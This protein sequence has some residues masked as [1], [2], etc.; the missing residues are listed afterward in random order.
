MKIMALLGDYPPDESKRRQNA[1]SRS[2]SPGTQ[3]DFSVISESVYRKGL[4]NLHRTL[5]APSLCRKAVEAEKAGYDAVVPYG[6]L[7]LG[8]EEA[9]HV[10]DIPVVGPGRAAVHTARTLAD[11]I[12]IVCY[13]EP[14]VVMFRKL[15]PFWGVERFATSIRPVNILVT[16]MASRQEDLRARFLD[17]ARAMIADEGAE[18]ILPLGFSMVPLT[19]AAQ[20]LTA[21][22]PVPVL[23]PMAISMRLAETLAATGVTNSRVAYPRASLD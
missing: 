20:D 8:V 12:G 6:T 3:V 7:D 10:V 18:V 17:I 2:A 15:L 5:A 22:L 13:D 11:R 23:D 4:T 1:M 9:R 19:L 21:E 14:H 16:E